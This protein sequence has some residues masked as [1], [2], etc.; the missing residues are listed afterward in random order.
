M[1]QIRELGSWAIEQGR[2]RFVH[3]LMEQVPLRDIFPAGNKAMGHLLELEEKPLV[4]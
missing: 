2:G 4:E 1:E 3:P